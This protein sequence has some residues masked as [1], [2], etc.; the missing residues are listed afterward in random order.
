MKERKKETN[1]KE[2]YLEKGRIYY[3]TK[4]RERERERCDKQKERVRLM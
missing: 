4:E 1:R 2:M 3:E